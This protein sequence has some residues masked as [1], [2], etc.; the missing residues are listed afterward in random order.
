MRVAIDA[1]AYFQ[2]TGIARYTRGLVH[3]LVDANPRA[4]FLIFISD[5]HV[6]GDVPIAHPRVE[7][8]VSRAPWLGGRT[9]RDTVGRDVT[10]WG[11]DVF[12]SIFPPLAVPGVPSVVTVFDL[13][14]LTHPQLHQP[15]VIDAFKTRMPAA[16]RDAAAIVTLSEATADQTRRRYR[17]ASG[18]IHVAGVGLPTRFLDAPDG[19]RRR[20]GALFVGTIEPRK[21][22]PLVIAAARRLHARGLHLPLTVV[23]K[24]GWGTFDVEA[25][26]ARLP[27][28]RYRG[29]VSDADL[30]R[31]YR[32]AAV[33]VYPSRVEGFGLPVLEAMSQG[34]L[35]LIS[36]DPALREV[37]ED[38]AL[39]VDWDD[40]DQLAETMARW[41]ADARSRTR[42]TVT[43][44]RRARRH[45]WPRV[46]RRVSAIYRSVA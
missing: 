12:H 27:N 28:V 17:S 5:R 38:P 32:S 14:P 36:P 26:I 9:E 8:Q 31:L 24:P 15:V 18:R 11:A 13:T 10:A 44:T 29:Y 43:L 1:R 40:A 41:C 33:F 3:A 20:G 6:P 2:R 7:I 30:R 4:R 23:G 19:D 37:V 45:T 39:V 25:E 22:V 16:L 35:P 34:A 21:N 42:K 46:A